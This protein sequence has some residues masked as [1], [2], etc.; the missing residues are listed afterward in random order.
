MIKRILLIF[1]YPNL[2]FDSEIWKN[3]KNYRSC[4]INKIL[5]K[6][7]EIGVDKAELQEKFGAAWMIYSSG[8]WSYEVP[9]L[10]RKKKKRVLNFYFDEHGKIKDIKIKYRIRRKM[11]SH[12]PY[13]RKS[14]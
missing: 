13:Y 3:N 1:R 11:Y 6:R 2:E 12:Y 9:N 5:R 7:K 8:A 14:N 4:F 10:W